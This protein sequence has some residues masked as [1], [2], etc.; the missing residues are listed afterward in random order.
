MMQSRRKIELLAPARDAD[1]AIEAVRHGADAV[2]MGASAFGA[3]ASA[4]ND[5]AGVARAVDFA[6]SAVAW[7][8]SSY[9]SQSILSV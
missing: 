3:R 7:E 4:G 9:L 1:I 6:C 5:L 2:Y 8:P